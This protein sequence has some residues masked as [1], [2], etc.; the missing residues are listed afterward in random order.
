MVGTLWGLL[1]LSM[2]VYKIWWPN[3]N[4]FERD[5]GSTRKKKTAF[6]LSVPTIFVWDCSTVMCILTGGGGG[7]GGVV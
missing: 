6:G 2:F 4:N 5:E 7:G 1:V 3:M